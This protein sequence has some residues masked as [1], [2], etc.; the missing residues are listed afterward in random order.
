MRCSTQPGSVSEAATRIAF[1]HLTAEGAEQVFT[2]HPDGTQIHQITSQQQGENTSP[3]WSPDGA[4]LC[5]VSRRDGHSSLYLAN[6]DGSGE[7]RLTMVEDVDDDLP[8]WSSDGDTIAFCR[9]NRHGADVLCLIDVAS[10]NERVLTSEGLL[11]S[12]PSWSPDG[13]WIVF[14]R[15]FGRPPGLYAIPVK[16][17]E[18]L[19]LVP[20]QYPSWSPLGGLIAYAHGAGLWVMEVDGSGMALGRA[21]PVVCESDLVVRR[22]S[23][24]P[25]ATTLVFDAEI[26]SA[27]SRTRRIMTVDADGT[28]RRDL[29]EG[30]DPDWSPPLQAG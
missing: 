8:A 14:R 5:L 6:A 28:N 29:A 23:W 27:P 11:D 3:S 12:S 20:G 15:T 17:G 7:E 16:A 21:R 4:R 2:M 1:C 25:D 19:F 22:S 24:S 9:G 26:A 10:R 18:A 30:Y 13:C